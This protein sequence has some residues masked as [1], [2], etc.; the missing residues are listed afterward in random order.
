[1]KL[2]RKLLILLVIYAI[3]SITVFSSM[4]VTISNS[5]QRALAAAYIAD[6]IKNPTS[7]TEAKEHFVKG[8]EHYKIFSGI[9]DWPPLQVMLLTFSFLIFGFNK[10]SFMIAPLIVTLL[11]LTYIYKLTFITYKD[12]KIALLATAITAVS[13]F[14]FYEAATPML[15][16]GLTLFTIMAIYHFT[17]YI[18]TKER[19]QF[20]CTAAAF[21]LGFLYKTQMIL[22]IPAL[23]IIFLLKKPLKIKKDCKMLAY[24]ALIV[25][26]IL[27]PLIVR[28]VILTKQ[29]LSTFAERSVGRIPYIY[30]QT[31]LPGYLTA[32][33]FEFENELPEYKIN[34]ITNRYNMSYLQKFVA[35]ITSLFYNWIALPFVLIGILKRKKQTEYATTEK[36][37]LLFTATTILFFTLHGLIP[38]HIIPTF[39][40][41]TPFAA[42]GIFSLPKKAITTVSVIVL[43]IVA[44]Q[45][46]QFFTKIYNNEH[47]QSMQHDYESAAEYVLENT[48]GEVTIITTRLYQMAYNIMKHDK[49]RRVYVELLPEK[50]EQLQE[51][52]SGRFGV[53]EQIKGKSVEYNAVRPRTAYVI[54]HQYL[55]TGP[56]KE[57]A[58]YNAIEF[59]ENHPGTELEITIASKYPNSTTWI[60][61]VN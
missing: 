26:V 59:L 1:M 7:L 55:E 39:V 13:T 58:D 40:L 11:T 46:T 5:Y 27:S 60:Y 33:D 41:L 56:L 32:E 9:A 10:I 37:I 19:K 51:M 48:E 53:P 43:L 17:E 22:I 47:I 49:E 57:I 50:Q 23:L 34:L 45:T 3:I 29:G 15:E 16:N 52:L 24:S 31:T 36:L 12:K 20:Y 8:Y 2:D 4:D 42:K 44:L 14:F 28:E 6:F 54:V 35:T 30:E 18:D 61:R 25:L 21:A 38:R